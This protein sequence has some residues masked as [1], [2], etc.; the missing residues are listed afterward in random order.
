LMGFQKRNGKS[1]ILDLLIL[2]WA[3]PLNADPEFL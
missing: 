1:P 2:V 3:L